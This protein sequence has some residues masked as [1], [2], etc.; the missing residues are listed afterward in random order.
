VRPSHLLTGGETITLPPLE[1][2]ELHAASGP[3]DVQIVYEDEDL[4]V[5]NKPAGLLVHPVGGEFRRT[6]LNGLHHR[7]TSRGEDPGE[8]GIVH[9]LDRLT[10]GLVVVAKR[11]AARR[12]LSSD[13]EQR[14][15]RR[16]YLAL[17]AGQPASQRGTVDLHIRRD[18]VRPTRMQAL[19]AE[20]VAEAMRAGWRPRV[21]ASGYSDPR[22]DL[23]PRPA[24]THFAVLRR[25]HGATLLRLE[26]ETGRTHQIR[27]HLQGIGVPILGDPIYGPAHGTQAAAVATARDL[28]RPAL[29]AASLEFR[30]PRTGEPLH[31]RAALPADMRT[32]LSRLAQLED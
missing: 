9:R 17:V 28:G 10:S 23:R 13:V 25:F 12:T 15:V 3:I 5:V 2:R 6:L 20:A 7:M 26:L 22:L 8:L 32:L 30:H 16:R 29:H 14:E 31:F 18:P 19:D 4:V 24:R 27:V 1:A 11:L 21:S